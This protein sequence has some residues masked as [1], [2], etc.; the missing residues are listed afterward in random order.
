MA[1]NVYYRAHNIVFLY[2]MNAGENVYWIFLS[3]HKII[4]TS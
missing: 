3:H 1:R 2:Y 4:Y